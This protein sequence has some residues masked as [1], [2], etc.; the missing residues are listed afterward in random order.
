MFK[1]G[2][3]HLGFQ[4]DL[5]SIELVLNL[6]CLIRS[7]NMDLSRFYFRSGFLSAT[8]SVLGLNVSAS[9]DTRLGVSFELFFLGV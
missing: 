1:L 3:G 7:L 8:K 4:V 6:R 9:E 5:G 2:S